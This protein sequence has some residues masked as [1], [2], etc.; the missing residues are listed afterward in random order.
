MGQQRLGVVAGLAIAIRAQ[1]VAE[2][3]RVRIADVQGLDGGKGGP[4]VGAPGERADRLH[5]NAGVGRP[6]QLA[7]L[8]RVSGFV[9]SGR[10]HDHGPARPLRLIDQ[11]R[12][13]VLP[14]APV[15]RRRPVVVDHHQQRPLAEKPAPRVEDRVGQSDDQQR[16]DDQAQQQQPPGRVRG[17]FFLLFQPEQQPYR[18]KADQARRRRRHPQQPPQH[19]QA[20]QGDQQPGVREDDGS[21]GQ[22]PVSPRSFRTGW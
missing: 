10:H 22:H 20:R 3:N 12:H 11:P 21:Q 1:P 15:R 2:P 13:A 5:Q 4:A 18:G 14:G 17:R 19:R 6:Q 9:G 8:D 16:R 7:C